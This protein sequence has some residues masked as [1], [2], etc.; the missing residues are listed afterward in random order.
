MA[1]LPNLT[2]R[3]SSVPDV[4]NGEIFKSVGKYARGAVLFAFENIGGP[5]ALAEWA[6]DNPTDFYTKLF[7]KIITREVE[8]GVTRSVD[9]LM[10]VID[11]EP[12]CTPEVAERVNPYAGMFDG[13]N[14]GLCEHDEYPDGGED[15]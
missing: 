8:V 2:R 5:T 14:E 9:E 4:L 3:S 7:P 10:D 11:A 15:E 12:V 6:A 13:G 1:N